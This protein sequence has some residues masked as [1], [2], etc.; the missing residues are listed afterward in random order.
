METINVLTLVETLS[1]HWSIA[2]RH[3]VPIQEIRASLVGRRKD[4]HVCDRQL[5]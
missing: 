2:N 3:H 5:V 4:Q 1:D